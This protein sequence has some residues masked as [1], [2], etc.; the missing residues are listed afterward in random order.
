MLCN[1]SH[2]S[3]TSIWQNPELCIPNKRHFKSDLVSLKRKK[4][5]FMV[6]YY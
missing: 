4:N 5:T 6:L 1:E 3:L 2:G